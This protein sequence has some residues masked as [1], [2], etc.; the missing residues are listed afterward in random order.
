[1]TVVRFRDGF[2]LAR[3]LASV[4]LPRVWQERAAIASSAKLAPR[5][6]TEGQASRGRSD[7]QDAALQDR[8]AKPRVE[9]KIH[10]QGIVASGVIMFL[11][12]S[13]SSVFDPVLLTFSYFSF[14]GK[15]SIP[16]GC[17]CG[18]NHDLNRGLG[19]IDY[20]GSPYE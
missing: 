2:V 18:T 16:P 17:W 8:P 14:T 1:M 6:M 10:I 13:A 20:I 11:L 5:A 9:G 12:L 4:L 7:Q 15:L 3:R 19:H